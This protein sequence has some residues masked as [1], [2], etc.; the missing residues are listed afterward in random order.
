M[1]HIVKRN[2]TLET[3]DSRKVYASMYTSCL[4]VHETSLVAELVAEKVTKDVDTWM[5]K[6]TEVTA[7]DIRTFAGKKLTEIN[8]HAG[9][10]YLHHRIMW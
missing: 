2:S 7:N 3:Y 8:P 1:K 5:A 6:K 10:L 9:Y 4:S